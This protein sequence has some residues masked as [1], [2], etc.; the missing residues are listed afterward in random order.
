MPD[1]ALVHIMS[2]RPPESRFSELVRRYR[3]SFDWTGTW[4]YENDEALRRP[5]G[6]RGFGICTV[7]NGHGSRGG[8][9]GGG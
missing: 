3:E 5:S 7:Q 6:V 8:G 1:A 4:Y 2:T 9:F